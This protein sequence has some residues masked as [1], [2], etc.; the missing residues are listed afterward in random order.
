MDTCLY[1][2][3]TG[4]SPS[5]TSH[6]DTLLF[7]KIV[8][9]LAQYMSFEWIFSNL[10]VFEVLVEGFNCQNYNF[11]VRGCLLGIPSNVS[12]SRYSEREFRGPSRV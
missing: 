2:T 5:R 6:A 3:S 12:M 7:T 10:E 4:R 11:E 9:S 1:A 8:S